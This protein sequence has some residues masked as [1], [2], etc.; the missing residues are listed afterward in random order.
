MLQLGG[1][2]THRQHLWGK[3]EGGGSRLN[4]SS[5]GFTEGEA[6]E[7]NGD[8]SLKTGLLIKAAAPALS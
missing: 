1:G 6:E 5:W 2:N 8:D 3:K 7:L 4:E